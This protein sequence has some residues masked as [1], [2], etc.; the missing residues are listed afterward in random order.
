V[1]VYAEAE[2]QGEADKLADEVRKVVEE[3]TK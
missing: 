1:R 2:T 3:L